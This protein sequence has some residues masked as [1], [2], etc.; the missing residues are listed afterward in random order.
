MG[1]IA[2]H[3]ICNRVDVIYEHIKKQY[4]PIK[5]LTGDIFNITHEKL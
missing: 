2:T 5:F 3:K 4:Q 1:G